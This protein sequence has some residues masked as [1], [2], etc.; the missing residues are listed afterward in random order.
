MDRDWRR[1]LARSVRTG[2]ELA[3]HL[4]LSGE[5]RRG[6]ELAAHSGLPFRVTP[7]Y[8][9]LVD[10]RDPA[11]PIRRQFVPLAREWE[12]GAGLRIDPLGE[13]RHE[14]A[15]QLIRRY[16]DRALLLVSDRCATF[17]R[18]CTRRR[19]VGRGR[20][21]TLDELEPALTWLEAHEEVVEVLVS[22]GDPLV[23]SD[24]WLDALLGR[25]RRI[26]HLEVI[27]LGTRA[28]VTLPMRIDQS[29]CA[30]LRRHGPLFVATHFNHP[31]E[32]T[33]E[34]VRACGALVEAG[35][36][37]VN[38]AVLLLGVNDCARTQAELGRALLRAR[39]KPYYLMQCD[40]AE[41]TAHLRVPLRRGVGIMAALRG[42]VS[43]L[44]IPTYVLDLPGGAGKV[45]LSPSA[46][47]RRE[48]EEVVFRGPRGQR[49]RYIDSVDEGE[50]C[51]GCCCPPGGAEVG[52]RVDWGGEIGTDQSS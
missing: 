3:E 18:H 34:A 1:Q 23:A 28:P 21:Q 6:L 46:L 52:E 39:V 33:V 16:S 2:G 4:E 5:E 38:Q 45:E 20:L 26:E 8:L 36:P 51:L 50:R 10:R 13:E 42:A 14:V 41:G 48:G 17:C 47:E 22:G 25:L 31:R 37:V 29:L 27:R 7:Y 11:D 9:S 35:V 40:A 19:R 30:V 44:A 15:P 32:V 43:G 49:V 12:P 24:L